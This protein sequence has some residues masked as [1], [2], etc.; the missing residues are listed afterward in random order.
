LTPESE[1]ARENIY[2]YRAGNVYLISPGGEAVPF[3]LRDGSRLWGIDRSG[4]DVFFA[5]NESLVPQDTDTQSSWYDA[6]ELGGFPAPNGQPSCREDACQGP[7]SVAPTLPSVP[8]SAL[9]PGVAE[10]PVGSHRP[11]RAQKLTK[12][13]KTCA[14]KPRRRRATCIKRARDRYGAKTSDRRSR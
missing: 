9:T 3:D 7:P 4:H 8:A 5:T 12:A 2:E 11:S 1:A 13:L 10:P 6:R 14:K